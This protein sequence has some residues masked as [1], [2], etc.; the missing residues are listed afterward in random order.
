MNPALVIF[1]HN[2]VGGW[3][4]VSS[5]SLPVDHPIQR[6]LANHAGGLLGLMGNFR[7]KLRRGTWCK[8]PHEELLKPA[9]NYQDWSED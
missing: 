3:R 9:A 7:R 4:V 2:P 6:P 1:E 8:R 5:L